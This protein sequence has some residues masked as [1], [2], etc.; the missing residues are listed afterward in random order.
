M[1]LDQMLQNIKDG[2]KEELEASKSFYSSLPEEEVVEPVDVYNRNAT[3]RYEESKKKRPNGSS[4]LV[5]AVVKSVIDGDGDPRAGL[6][7]ALKRAEDDCDILRR[8]GERSRAD[9]ARQQYMEERFIPAVEVVVNYTSPD[10]V[11]NCKEALDELDKYALG[12]GSS[13]GYT[14]S[15][16]RQAYGDLLGQDINGSADI[17]DQYVA[18]KVRAI[19]MLSE[20]D[21]IRTAVS[22][23]KQ[24][25]ASVDKGE[26][27]A[28]SDDY[29]L[30][31]RVANF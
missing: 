27:I 29:E 12:V 4:S 16:I 5:K 19:K 18:E 14:A 28:N 15:Y 10:E 8:N 31:G 22:L 25:K 17:S 23:A 26:H 11:L 6:A 24:T 3:A 21:D 13:K 30:L 9:I 7:H 2:A 1:D 20:M